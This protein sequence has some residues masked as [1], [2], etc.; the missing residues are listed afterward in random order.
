MK[1]ISHQDR[2][3]Y[4]FAS[5]CVRPNTHSR[6]TFWHPVV[7]NT[8]SALY[9]HY[10]RGA[11]TSNTRRFRTHVVQRHLL[12][13]TSRFLFIFRGSTVPKDMLYT[14]LQLFCCGESMV[15]TSVREVTRRWRSKH[16]DGHSTWT[17]DLHVNGCTATQH[18]LGCYNG[19][20]RGEYVGYTFAKPF[21]KTLAFC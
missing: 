8:V 7:M 2:L 1:L 15:M 12:K 21:Q 4:Q 14:K 3:A 13:Q 6:R 16:G 11:C 19:K 9:T 20:R 18:N 5:V 17:L 10:G